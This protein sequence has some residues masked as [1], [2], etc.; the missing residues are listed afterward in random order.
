M[1]L[2]VPD[3]ASIMSVLAAFRAASNSSA[4]EFFSELALCKVVAHRGLQRPLTIPRLLRP[5]G[6]RAAR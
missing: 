3:M 1:V 5:A 6:I 4:F 2:G